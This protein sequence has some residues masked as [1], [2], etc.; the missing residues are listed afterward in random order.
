MLRKI[1]SCV[2]YVLAA[3]FLIF[4]VWAFS[5]SAE[6]ISEAIEMGQI[7]LFGNLYDIVGFYMANTGAYFAYAFLLIGAGLLLGTK[8]G[9][10]YHS[11]TGVNAHNKSENDAELDEW[12]GDNK[13]DEE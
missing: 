5:N 12:F 6:I 11:V 2:F 13:E 4:A 10:T 1:A 3:P 8:E 9:K 7:T